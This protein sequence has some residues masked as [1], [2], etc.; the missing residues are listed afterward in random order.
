Q[1]LIRQ[2]TAS[3]NDAY[4]YQ[5]ARH[6]IHDCR[7]EAPLWVLEATPSEAGHWSHNVLAR[8]PAGPSQRVPRQTAKRLFALRSSCERSDAAHTGW[9]TNTRAAVPLHTRYEL[10]GCLG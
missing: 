5:E 6:D 2:G 3:R 1:S 4:R 8:C 10:D 9:C 7:I